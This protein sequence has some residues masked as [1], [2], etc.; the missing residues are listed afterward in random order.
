MNGRYNLGKISSSE[1]EHTLVS[2]LAHLPKSESVYVNVLEFV[3]LRLFDC[4]PEIIDKAIFRNI[5]QKGV[6]EI[7][8]DYPTGEPEVRHGFG[9]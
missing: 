6:V 3:F 1:H 9:G 4:S 8:V 5:N 2:G 7:R